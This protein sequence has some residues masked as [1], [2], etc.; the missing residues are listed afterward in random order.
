MNH[1]E[2]MEIFGVTEEK[3]PSV[4][5]ASIIQN[6]MDGL[7]FEQADAVL[8]EMAVMLSNMAQQQK[9]IIEKVE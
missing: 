3:M 7:T 5:A 8:G 1:Q 2:C 4:L 9:I 6:D